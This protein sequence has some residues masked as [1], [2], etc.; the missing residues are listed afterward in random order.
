MLPAV[1]ATLDGVRRT[2][3]LTLAQD[4]LHDEMRGSWADTDGLEALAKRAESVTLDA[5]AI[6]LY[7]DG[8]MIRTA[9]PLGALTVDLA[10][11]TLED[12]ASLISEYGLVR[13]ARRRCTAHGTSKRAI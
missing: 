7:A 13:P 5:S 4:L 9:A 8:R 3:V 10:M 2:A 1:M 6:T 11:L 12:K